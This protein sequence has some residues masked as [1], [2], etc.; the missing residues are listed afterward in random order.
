MMVSRNLSRYNEGDPP[1]P[2]DSR[3]RKISGGPLYPAEE[4]LGVMAVGKVQVA[5]RKARDDV[6]S[7]ELDLEDLAAML[8]EALNEGLYHDSEWCQ[9]NDKGHWAA[10]DS[11]RLHRMEW[12]DAAASNIKVEYYIK[13][14]IGCTGT[15]L[16]LVS[17]HL[18]R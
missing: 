8:R 16:L 3:S 10:C 7:L 14:A 6:R 5:T 11:Y 18:S 2:N 15:L 13:F 12:I 1:K 4:V 17:C 9:L